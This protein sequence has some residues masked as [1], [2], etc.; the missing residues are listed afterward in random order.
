VPVT[1]TRSIEVR[2]DIRS[3]TVTGYRLDL[4]LTLAFCSFNPEDLQ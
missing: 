1:D 2:G 4:I 3:T